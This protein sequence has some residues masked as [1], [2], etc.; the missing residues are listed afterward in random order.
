MRQPSVLSEGDN[1][2]PPNGY[3]NLKING[4]Y[5][6]ACSWAAQAIREILADRTL[7][8]WAAAQAGHDSLHG[9][10]INYGVILPAGIDTGESSTPV[11]VRRNRHGGLL[12]SITGEY[13]QAPTRAPLELTNALRL[14]SAGVN[15]PEVVAYALYPAFMN[16]VRCD[17]VTRRL[18][19][20]GDF[21]D[22]WRKAD[23]STRE[24]L[25]ASVASLLRDLF[26]AGA[27][28]A[29]LNLKNIYIAGRGS[30]I[31]PYMLDVDRVSFPDC[32]DIA[33]RNFKRLA[34]SARKWRTKWGLDFDEVTLER[35][36]TL[37]LEMN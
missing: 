15:T 31:T 26:K 9:R 17:V 8:E 2:L 10:G 4:R 37:T 29:D 27:W 21:P 33:E 14:A 36:A 12:G 24:A 11:V 5:A 30:D 13:F 34:R 19:E 18:P 35:L 28:H 6:V 25:M 3:V 1:P 16:L 32:K 23:S 22:V 20:G 7:H